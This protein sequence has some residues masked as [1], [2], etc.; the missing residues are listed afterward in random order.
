MAPIVVTCEVLKL[1]KLIEVNDEH[2]LNI[3]CI[4]LTFEVFKLDKF[5]EVNDEHL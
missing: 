5:N 4:K 2:R 1:D 3:H